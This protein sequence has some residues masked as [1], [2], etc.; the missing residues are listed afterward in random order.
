MKTR[1]FKTRFFKLLTL[2]LCTVFYGSTALATP[3]V[4]LCGEV[5]EGQSSNNNSRALLIAVDEYKDPQITDLKGTLFDACSIR[6]VLIQN[7]GFSDSNVTLIAN[8]SATQS[9]IKSAIENLISS[10]S[11]TDDA[12]VFF[13][14]H[15][16]QIP[17]D[18]GEEADN[19]DETILPYDSY[20]SLGS[21]AIRDIRDDDLGRYFDRLAS[22]SKSLSVI[23]D[24][25]HSGTATRSAL[26]SRFVDR[27]I[28]V[29]KVGAIREK[30]LDR[31][32]VGNNNFVFISSASSNE[33][34]KEVYRNGQS[35]GAFT[36]AFTE[37][38]EKRSE[39]HSLQEII[40]LVKIELEKSG[41]RD[42]TPQIEGAKFGEKFLGGPVDELQVIENIPAKG[43]VAKKVA[44][45]ANNFKIA[46]GQVNGET[47]GSVY[48]IVSPGSSGEKLKGT[49]IR[50]ETSS[51]IIEF[52]SAISDPEIRVLK[53]YHNYENK[54]PKFSMTGAARALHG[55]ILS[56]AAM[57]DWLVSN[58]EEAYFVIDTD[59]VSAD[60]TDML[61][62]D[63]DGE[64][65]TSRVTADELVDKMK[66]WDRWRRFREMSDRGRKSLT[67]AK[68]I[69]PKCG[70]FSSSKK[71]CVK[72][73]RKGPKISVKNRTKS[74]IYVNFIAVN[75]TGS[76]VQSGKP[77]KLL[78]KAKYTSPALGIIPAEGDKENVIIKVFASQTPVDLS[79]FQ[80][81]DLRRADSPSC[82]SS[83][84]DELNSLLCSFNGNKRGRTKVR[85]D[86][87]SVDDLSITIFPG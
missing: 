56:N 69:G 8:K 51:A 72:P 61:I 84:L 32:S 26:R 52:S 73:G 36:T 18:N 50:T 41:I 78:A 42:Q 3:N 66:A 10:S 28:A 39:D 16:S 44:G 12:L 86:N 62:L 59:Y 60:K 70:F 71:A 33:K 49:V 24:S 65:L 7:Y 77:I 19:A 5:Y 48:E 22:K 47:V 25:C 31:P 37:L 20:R 58:P 74:T 35:R 55:T 68:F 81:G 27:G 45:S 21:S 29:G 38:L 57:D 85:T 14:G 4:S 1:S 15:G 64:R 17:D 76:I 6:R 53:S 9:G 34:A 79:A 43:I 75:P 46:S 2:S 11:Q 87:W 54:P 83:N 30:A 80:Q 40:A 82:G 23:F 63:A 13:A 67:K